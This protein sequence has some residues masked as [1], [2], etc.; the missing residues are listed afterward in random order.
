MT[1]D[2]EI[3]E[4]D[5][6]GVLRTLPTG[7]V[8]HVVT[9]PPYGQTNEGYDSPVAFDPAVWRE[10]YR[11]TGPNAALVSFAGSPTYHKIASAIE[12]GGWNVR[13]MWGW[14]YRNGFITSAWPREGFDRLAP[15]M[16]PIC[17]ATKGKVLLDLKREGDAIWKRDANSRGR[18][19]FSERTSSHGLTQ[20]VGH[21]PRTLTSDGVEGFEY[22]N[23]APNSTRM[24][25]ERVGHPNQK[26][27]KLLEWLVGKL[28]N[29]VILDPFAGS[30][31]TGIA[32]LNLGY[33]FIGVE[34]DPG[35]F[36]IA[37]GRLKACQ[38]ANDQRLNLF[39]PPPNLRLPEP[40]DTKPAFRQI[41]IL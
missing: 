28:P 18:P 23:L 37:D 5:C 15:A 38:A 27:V 4:G 36:A 24:K 12:A 6:L 33:G 35:Y 10:C 21:W 11:V 9:D 20:A 30:G 40:D 17:F 16:D 39:G 34:R 29:G 26:P 7:S 3:I 25:A 19:S 8:G 2:C 13:Q 22:F 32:C 1:D 14:V 31:T 41:S